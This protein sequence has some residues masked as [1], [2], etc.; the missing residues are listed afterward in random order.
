MLAPEW[1]HDERGAFARSYCAGELRE[2]GLC[3]AFEQQSISRTSRARTLRGLHFQAPPHAEAKLIR[4]TRGAVY[5]VLVDLRPGSPT[6]GRWWGME[7][8]ARDALTLYVPTGLAHGFVT[9]VDDCE[10]HYQMSA[11]YEPSAAGGVRWDD[12][13]FGIAWPVQ[14]QL[15]SERDRCFPDWVSPAEE[16][17]RRGLPGA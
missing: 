17:V 16:L 5:D 10:L 13:A 11:A 1:R 14:P 6:L 15:I 8:T 2:R 4:C 7:L 3:T 9:L 12:P